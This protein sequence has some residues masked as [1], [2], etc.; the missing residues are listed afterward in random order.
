MGGRTALAQLGG[1]LCAACLLMLLTLAGML[2]GAA[3]PAGAQ[4]AAD[5]PAPRAQTIQPPDYAA[6]KAEAAVAEEVINAGRA[7]TRAL[8]DMRARLVTWRGQF[9]AAKG[10]NA[11]QIETLKSQIAA[12]GPAPSADNPE[13]AEIAQRRRELSET[14]SRVQAPSLS[15]VEAFS[16]AD[17]LIRQ[18]DLLIRSRQANAL[19]TLLPSPLNPLH[20]QSGAAVLTQGLNTLRFE[21]EQ[22]WANPARQIEL[23]ANMPVIIV[24]LILA[25]LLMARGAAFMEMLAN[26]FQS[27][28]T[29]RGRKI[30]AALISFGEVLVP[31]GGMLLLVVAVSLSGMT[32]PRLQAL[33]ESLPESAF[34]FF[35]ARW[36]G[37]WLFPNAD[38]ESPYLRM[39]D[40]PAEARFLVMMIGLIV[41]I[42]AFR[43]SFTTDVRPPL[44]QAAQAVWLAPLVC[45]VASPLFR[46]GA[47]L[48]RAP[49]EAGAVLQ[50]GRPAT[51][52]S[53]AQL[54][55]NRIV[56]LLGAALMVSAVVAPV[57][58]LIGYVAAANALIWP[59][60]S[61]IAFGGF[62][63]LVQRGLTEV[64]V[65]I[66][67]SG[68]EGREALLP[69][70][71]GFLLALVAMPVLALTWGV[72]PSDL[73]EAWARFN[74]GFALGTTQI[75]PS[76]VLTLL[77]VF[78]LGYM[79]TRL[80][81]GAM[82]SMLLPRTKLDRGAQ[83]AAVA[84]T[85]YVG[86]ALAAL[87]AFS[88]AGIDLSGL[89]IVAGALS[90]GIGFGLQNIV[91]NFIAGIIL[92]IERPITEGDF[93]E[94]GGKA[95][96]TVKA[97][98]VRSTRITTAD[99][100]EVIVPNAEFIS[101]VVTNWTRE[102]LQGR[103]VLPVIVSYGSD[104]RQVIQI[105]RDILEAQPLVMIDP[106]PAVLLWRFGPQGLEFEIRALL[107][108]LN[109][110]AAVQSDVNLQILERFAAAGIRMPLGYQEIVLNRPKTVRGAEPAVAEDDLT[111][112]E[113]AR[114]PR[115]RTARIN[116]DP[117]TDPD[118]NDQL[119]DRPEGAGTSPGPAAL[120]PRK[121]DR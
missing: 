47:L 64:Y 53:D 22:A 59:A 117:S 28:M 102:S 81:Q 32:G 34:A 70:L 40:R 29:M 87:A 35:F 112:A 48:R 66:T 78:A 37:T 97:I 96:G 2:A 77:V 74:S 52:A 31:V 7:S 65:V 25:V 6:W 79:V 55:R 80:L 90:V 85:G 20:W 111:P 62:I 67:K 9:D 94:V 101:G 99:Q 42:E 93:I 41:G 107:A 16:Q 103:L 18:T 105:L 15:A 69:V 24:S 14:L 110:K 30:L 88:A 109:F 46:L 39:T 19:L 61:S 3:V 27:R 119:R 118:E 26:R 21:V 92:L 82:R 11:Q 38:D 86:L 76:G 115:Q 50:G 12:L 51:G 36:L 121:P 91:Q 1:W 75:S 68:E 120:S 57:L 33:I 23:R 63:L 4:D 106:A 71:S 10:I 98:S 54:F 116:N 56:S 108:D 8:E 95:T 104:P 5:A 17:G 100:A 43:A 113:G 73:L 13:A 60:I 89:A 58:A 49:V 84:G 83:N 114:R 72:R 44:S 45:L